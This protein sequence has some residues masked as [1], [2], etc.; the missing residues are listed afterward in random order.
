MKSHI[1]TSVAAA[2]VVGV[3]GF[4]TLTSASATV[5]HGAIVATSAITAPASYQVVQLRVRRKLRSHRRKRGFHSGHTLC[6]RTCTLWFN[7]LTRRYEKICSKCQT[8]RA[9]FN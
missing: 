7:P 5:S 8:P 1:I 6:R 2:I 4:T 3:A 9:T